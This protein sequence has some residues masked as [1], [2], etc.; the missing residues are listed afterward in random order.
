MHENVAM[1]LNGGVKAVL[2]F[3][4]MRSFAKN[5]MP[6]LPPGTASQFGR[7]G[8]SRCEQSEQIAGKMVRLWQPVCEDGEARHLLTDAASVAQGEAGRSA[9]APLKTCPELLLALSSAQVLLLFTPGYKSRLIALILQG[10]VTGRSWT[11]P[12]ETAQQTSRSLQGK[13]IDGS[14]ELHP[15]SCTVKMNVKMRLALLDLLNTNHFKPP[16]SK[17]Y[18]FFPSYFYFIGNGE[19]SL[20]LVF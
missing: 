2:T 14:T 6:Q 17:K 16:V 4:G 12:H 18:F 15:P 11:C 19:N 7:T 8:G 10:A 9:L 1:L 3:M 20:T 13:V 5:E